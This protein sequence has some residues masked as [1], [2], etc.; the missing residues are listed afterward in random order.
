MVLLQSLVVTI[1]KASPDQ[2]LLIITPEEFEDEILPL[3]QFKDATNRPSVIETLE[4]IYTNP[5]YSSAD[6]EAEKIKMCIADYE[7]DH[8]IKYVLL[9]G[10]V[11]WLPMRYFY[12]KRENAT[13]VGWLQYYLT[14][15]Y[16]A[17]L[18][19]SGGSFCT[20]DANGNGI[21][22]EIYDDDNDGDY[23]NDDG[24]DFEFDVVVG[25]IPVDTE[26]E[27]E[28]YVDKVIS[29][30]T[31]VFYDSWFKNIILAT[32]TGEWIYPEEGD[33]DDQNE[34]DLIATEMATAGF[35]SIKLYH[36][37][38]PGGSYYPN[39]TNIN[40][41][42]NAGAGFINVISHG[43]EFSWGVYDVR[44]DM[45]GLT[46]QDKLTVVYSFGCS[47]AKVGPIA[48]ADPYYDV[49][50]VYRDYGAVY[51][52]DYYPCPIGD[53]VEPA[54]PDPLQGSATDIDCMP[55]YWNFH[56]DTGAVAFVGSTAESSSAMGYPVMHYFYESF[57]T[58]GHRVLG[59]LW[60]SVSDKV[61]A[62]GHS[63]GTD[64]DHA[65]RW[66]YINVFGDPTL[67]LG[68]LPD[69]PPITFLSIGSPK[70]EYSGITYVTSSTP[71]NLYPTDDFGVVDTFYKYDGSWSSGTTFT[72]AGS[73]GGYTVEYYST[74]TGG[75][76]EYPIK[77]E[78]VT[79]DNSA[80]T[81]TL[82]IGTPKVIDGL[83]TYITS[84]TYITLSATDGASG[85]D[86]TQYRIDGGGWTPY[87]VP[88]QLSEADGLHTIYYRSVDKLG[89]TETTK[90]KDVILDNTPP[91]IT[92]TVGTPQYGTTPLWV[93]S[94]TE[95]TVTISDSG[96]GVDP[97]PE[98][99]YSLDGGP[100]V[101]Y[102]APFT[103]PGNE[104]DNARNVDI[105]IRAFDLL[106]NMGTDSKSV[107]LDNKPPAS[108][109]SIGDP[110]H[111]ESGTVYVTSSTDFSFDP[112]D[113]EDYGGGV[114][115]DYT[116]YRI[117]GGTWE[118][119]IAPFNIFGVDGIHTLEY[120]SVDYLGN[121]E[122]ADP[123][124]VFLDNTPPE[125][126]LNVGDPKH[127]SGGNTW[128]T[129]HTDLTLAATDAGSGVDYT[130]YRID[131]GGWILYTG[132]FQLTGPDGPY[133]VEFRSV[134]NL[135]NTE[136]TKS[137][138]LILDNTPPEV[139]VELPE[140]GD[141]VYGY[142]T[143]EI[144]ATDEGSGVHF[145]EYSLDGGTTWLL[146]TYNSGN[147][148]LGTW[149]TTT[150]TEGAHTIL[151]RAEDY[152]ENVG[153][154]ESPPTVNIVYLEYDIEFTDSNWNFI[155]EF[156]VVF[157]EQKPGTYK[158][159][160]NPG[161]IY[162]I[163]TITNTG[164]IVTLPELIL[165]IMIPIET[166]FLGPGEEAFELQGAKSIHVYLNGEDV[167]PKGNWQ[168]DLNNVDV[169]QAL[170]PGDTIEIYVHYEYSFKGEKYD[171]PD[172]SSWPGEDYIFISDILSA[173]GPS[174]DS[175]I[176]A[177]PVI[178]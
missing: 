95:F 177:I 105:D 169:M 78:L 77:T 42:L 54:E 178:E 166:D 66:L 134:D 83:D 44:T 101:P 73:D 104:N 46:N 143:I 124:E 7:A 75:N 45:S 18:Y 82:T 10:D 52:S 32:G 103:I 13:H 5:D 49:F 110:Y 80:P 33:D 165:D 76:T 9:V 59:D 53:W 137:Q 88:F 155:E 96:V 4:D 15:H 123:Y 74:D 159:N 16:Y 68:G 126:T 133:L 91:D 164:T 99:E 35:S 161:A 55:E 19:D 153:Y 71:F 11:D 72:I 12:L 23:T 21:Y 107:I 131:G 150:F 160:T 119:Y 47:T 14:D 167:T 122:E 39:P 148:W 28:R 128:V 158:I 27:V 140:D 176:S 113:W 100:Y 118:D 67:Y 175:I 79:L 2:D 116:K 130:E 154:D 26:V 102:T 30:E 86:Y 138:V 135:G 56:Y 163:I 36:D 61:H 157:N 89:N 127:S 43:N 70:Y 152:V 151:A 31:E 94:D 168:P 92:I 38:F 1:S 147:I 115:V 132:A 139:N 84:D 171:D 117:D 51:E 145:V 60:N 162:E 106:D 108:M 141:Y 149:D 48:A 58:D 125:T 98:I 142:I 37:N 114:G 174:W 24:I 144:S 20:W 63:I 29:Y 121:T 170:A 85:V 90:D 129:S 93:T 173:Y 136:T 156:N 34:S 112:M 8:N 111:F 22:G 81:T 120:Y 62:G 6:D 172:V 109:L 57:A 97:T 64:W 65:R 41:H 3:K 69:K 146:A 50:G 17:D 40:T 25:R 87:G